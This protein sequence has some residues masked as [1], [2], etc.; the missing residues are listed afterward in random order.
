MHVHPILITSKS[1][2]ALIF[3][4]L[5][6]PSTLFRLLPPNPF[7][8]FQ[9]SSS[10]ILA[11]LLAI[12]MLINNGVDLKEWWIYNNFFIIVKKITS[13]SLLTHVSFKVYTARSICLKL[14]FIFYLHCE[15]HSSSNYSSSFSL[16]SS[17]DYLLSHLIS[18]YLIT[19]KN[20]LQ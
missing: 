11:I 13:M 10:A 16:S 15:E 19:T 14:S 1:I 20:T 17:H 3:T 4:S 18:P 5:G 12:Y 2:C 6:Y 7:K 8:C 9:S